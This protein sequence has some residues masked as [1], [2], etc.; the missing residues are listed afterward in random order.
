MVS[1]CFCVKKIYD[2][3]YFKAE[4]QVVFDHFDG[5][6]SR[7]VNFVLK[8]LKSQTSKK[9]WKSWFKTMRSYNPGTNYVDSKLYTQLTEFFHDPPLPP[10]NVVTNIREYFETNLHPVIMIFNI[11]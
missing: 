7:S 6:L 3:V 1:S 10:F 5:S 9:T 8:L 11:D 2:R 4:I